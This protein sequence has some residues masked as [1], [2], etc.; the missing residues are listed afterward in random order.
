MHKLNLKYIYI[1]FKRH[2][3]K[4]SYN[5]PLV[6][7]WPKLNTELNTLFLTS[8]KSM[9]FSTNEK[10]GWQEVYELNRQVGKTQEEW[11]LENDD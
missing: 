11:K 1:F 5:M 9:D 2:K 3:V 10:Q 4:Y 6:N 7:K 8:Y